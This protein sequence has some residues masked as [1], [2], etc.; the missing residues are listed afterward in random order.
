MA[1]H[2]GLVI[3]YAALFVKIEILDM[4]RISISGGLINEAISFI[5]RS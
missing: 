2:K 4:S 1:G 3:V 5:Q